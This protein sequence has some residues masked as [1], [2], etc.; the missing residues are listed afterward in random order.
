MGSRNCSEEL[1]V[2][3]QLRGDVDELETVVGRIEDAHAISVIR[4]EDDLA[5][6]SLLLLLQLLRYQHCRARR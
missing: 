2:D 1:A 5:I 4:R 3:T 6:G